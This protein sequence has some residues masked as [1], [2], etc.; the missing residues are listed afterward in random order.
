[1]MNLAGV[2]QLGKIYTLIEPAFFIDKWI[3]RLKHHGQRL[4]DADKSVELIASVIASDAESK[5]IE[6]ITIAGCSIKEKAYIYCE[7]LIEILKSAYGIEAIVLDDVIYANKA[8]ES[9][10]KAHGVVLV[11][12]AGATLCNDF[13]KEIKLIQQLGVDALGGVIVE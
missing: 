5:E 13:D 6:N 2:F 3:F 10:A 8:M 7:R 4:M 9:L 1:M 11:E 12:T